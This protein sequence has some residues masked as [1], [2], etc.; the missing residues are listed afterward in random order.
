M[1]SLRPYATRS[2]GTLRKVVEIHP[3]DGYL[4]NSGI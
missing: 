3:F 4:I 2:S 1:K